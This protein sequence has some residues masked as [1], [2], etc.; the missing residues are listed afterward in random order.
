MTLNPWFGVF[1]YKAIVTHHNVCSYKDMT[2]R[3]VRVQKQDDK[4]DVIYTKL[5]KD[6]RIASRK[7]EDSCKTVFNTIVKNLEEGRWSCRKAF[8]SGFTIENS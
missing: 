6:E 8:A 2:Y 4:C 7:A 1:A 3:S 5:G